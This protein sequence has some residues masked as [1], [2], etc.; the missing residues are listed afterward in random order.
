MQTGAVTV[1]VLLAVHVWPSRVAVL[2]ALV[3]KAFIRVALGKLM[4][5]AALNV[6]FLEGPL[7][8]GATGALGRWQSE[9]DVLRVLGRELY[10]LCR[11]RQSDSKFSNAVLERAIKRRATIRTLSTLTKLAAKYPPT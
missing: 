1:G 11:E 3:K 6:A 4:G 8:A 9:T 7:D 10:W 5:A 2:S